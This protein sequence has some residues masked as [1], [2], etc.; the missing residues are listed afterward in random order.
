MEK[1]EKYKVYFSF[2]FNRSSSWKKKDS[3]DIDSENQSRRT[4]LFLKSDER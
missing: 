4:E 3:V 2:L 1:E